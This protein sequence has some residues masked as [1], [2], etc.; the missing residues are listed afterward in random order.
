M[1]NILV[2]AAVALAVGFGAAWLVFGNS[3]DGSSVTRA[4][5]EQLVISKTDADRAKCKKA[6]GEFSCTVYYR[7]FSTGKLTVRGTARVYERNG[8]AVVQASDDLQ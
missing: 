8:K 4:R 7:H 2:V 6:D 1:R 3:G 5:A